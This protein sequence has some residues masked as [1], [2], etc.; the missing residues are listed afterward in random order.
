MI[1][2]DEPDCYT[3]DRKQLHFCNECT[4][5]LVNSFSID[6]LYDMYYET[7]LALDEIMTWDDETEVASAIICKKELHKLIN[8][9]MLLKIKRDNEKV[10]WPD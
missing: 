4:E 8:K 6:D 9:L 2:C 5:K 7:T 3:N 10:E 1:H